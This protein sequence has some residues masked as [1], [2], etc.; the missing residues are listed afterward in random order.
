[1]NPNPESILG[2]ISI[3]PDSPT[4]IE[5]RFQVLLKPTTTPSFVTVAGAQGNFP[6][7]MVMNPGRWIVGVDTK[8]SLFLDYVVLMPQEYYEATILTQA[9]N[10][11]CQIGFEGLCRHYGYPTLSMFDTVLGTGGYMNKNGDRFVAFAR[12]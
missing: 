7:A 10:I 2:S 9:V 8:K 1:M 6:S 5:Q 3:T 11:P 12:Q 4:E